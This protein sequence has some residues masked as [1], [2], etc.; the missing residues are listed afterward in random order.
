MA[1]FIVFLKFVASVVR[2]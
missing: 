2:I 1:A